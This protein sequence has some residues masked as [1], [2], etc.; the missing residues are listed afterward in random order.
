MEFHKYFDVLLD[1]LNNNNFQPP[2]KMRERL[3]SVSYE[4]IKHLSR[5]NNQEHGKMA[6]ESGITLLSSHVEFFQRLVYNDYKHWYDVLRRLSRENRL[7]SAIT[8]QRALKTFY[9]VI[10]RI[11]TEQNIPQNKS[12]LLVSSALKI[13]NFLLINFNL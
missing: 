2:D 9:R 7:S 6:K 5:Q 8:G 4:W 13:R 11:L 3:F 12:I 1:I 10:G